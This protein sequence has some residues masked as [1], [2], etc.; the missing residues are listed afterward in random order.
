MIYLR[1]CCCWWRPCSSSPYCAYFGRS[2]PRR[3]GWR[4]W[5][6]MRRNEMTVSLLTSV[7]VAFE[8]CECVW[9]HVSENN[10]LTIILHPVLGSETIAFNFVFLHSFAQCPK[11][12]PDR[13][14]L[15]HFVGC[16]WHLGF[17][18]IIHASRRIPARDNGLVDC[19]VNRHFDRLYARLF[20]R[21]GLLLQVRHGQIGL[22]IC[23]AV[24]F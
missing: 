15:H 24:Y 19:H 20:H 11:V 9:S 3:S 8:Y 2:C 6:R 12:R 7:W 5:R 13:A 1:N 23:W 4:R 16:L 21:I 18:G 14:R 17:E 10:A 22:D